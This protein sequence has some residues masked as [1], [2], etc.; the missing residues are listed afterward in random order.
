MMLEHF[1]LDAA[2]AAINQAVAG[3]LAESGPRTADLGG[4]STTADV[5]TAIV[6]RIQSSVSH[7]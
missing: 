6:K 2:A 5:G 4:T 7:K 1:E 3:L